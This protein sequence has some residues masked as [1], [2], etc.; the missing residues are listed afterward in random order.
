[1]VAFRSFLKLIKDEEVL[2]FLDKD[3]N[4]AALGKEEFHAT[5]R[6]LTKCAAPPTLSLLSVRLCACVCACVFVCAI[7]LPRQWQCA[8][9]MLRHQGLAGGGALVPG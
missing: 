4:A 5:L 6:G 2:A 8:H 9:G 1:M 7:W 3:D